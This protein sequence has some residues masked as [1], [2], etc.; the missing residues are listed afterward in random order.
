MKLRKSI[1][2][3]LTSAARILPPGVEEC[4]RKAS[5]REGGEWGK[6]VLASIVRNIDI[7][8]ESGIP[9]CQDTGMFFVLVS[10]GRNARLN[11]ALLEEEI[12][13]GAEA[14]AKN[15]L[16]R[17]SVV[18]DPL[19]DRTNTG[20]NL[21]C[22]IYYETCDGPDITINF[23]LKGFGSENCSGVR[24]L[25]PTAGEDDVIE[26]VTDIMRNAGGKPCP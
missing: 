25:N 1:E 22:V 2:N 12:N 14:A 16:Y 4:I 9:L 7:S 20:T 21:P 15:S 6:T 13:A 26:A 17:K 24:M 23:L 10:I 3:A 11:L 8:R 19:H 5:E 18:R